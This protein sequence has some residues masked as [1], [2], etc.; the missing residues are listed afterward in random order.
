MTYEVLK[1]PAGKVKK[2]EVDPRPEPEVF[3]RIAARKE[4]DVAALLDA[5]KFATERHLKA[6]AEM[7]FALALAEDPK[8]ADALKGIGGEARFQ[9]VRKGNLQLHPEALAALERYM[10]EDDVEKRKATAVAGTTHVQNARAPGDSLMRR[11][12]SATSSAKHTSPLYC[13]RSSE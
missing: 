9:E 4:G 2:V 7:C 3:R 11:V 8:N 5:A 6:H 10:A 12:A 1:L 13:L